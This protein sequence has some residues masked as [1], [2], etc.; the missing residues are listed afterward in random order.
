MCAERL[1]DDPLRE[2]PLDST[3]V[4]QGRLLQV[5]VDRV[6]LPDGSEAVRE[7]AR[8][9]GAV[10]ILPLLESGEL[11]FERQFRYPLARSFLELPAGKIDP[12]EAP[13]ETAVRELREETGHVAGVWHH[14]GV[15]HPCIGYSN[16]RIEVFLARDLVQE[17]GPQP[18][19]GEFLEIL[20]LD[21]H[22]VRAAIRDGRITDAKTITAFC[23][24][25][26]HGW[27]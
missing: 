7:Y 18:D 8:H 12:G 27:P 19:P 24:A 13:A 20:T 25:E 15:M 21:I 3:L 11:L 4:F 6:R 22:A 23:M 9:P 17:S 10:V 14:L 16:E 5:H 1:I 2:T 26:L